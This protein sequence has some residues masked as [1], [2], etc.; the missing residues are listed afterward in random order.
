MGAERADYTI[1]HAVVQFRTILSSSHD[2]TI[3]LRRELVC[4]LV[5]ICAILS[6]TKIVLWMKYA[7]SVGRTLAIFSQEEEK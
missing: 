6:R 3:I 2:V 4:I 7:L 1:A 5:W